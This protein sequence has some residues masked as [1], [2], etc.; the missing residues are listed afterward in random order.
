MKR[1]AVKLTLIK[2][3]VSRV[4]WL[5]ISPSGSYYKDVDDFNEAT[6]LYYEE[7]A[8]EWCEKIRANKHIGPFLTEIVEAEK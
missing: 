7:S 4:K 8:E 1:Y 2:G 6:L 3:F 5:Y